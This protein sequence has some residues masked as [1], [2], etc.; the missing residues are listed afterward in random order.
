[1][2]K[3]L[4]AAGIVIGLLGL[5]TY[6]YIE[7]HPQEAFELA[8]RAERDRAMLSVKSVNVDGDN[9]PYLDGGEGDVVLLLHGFGGDKDNW[10][11]FGGHLTPDHRV[12][13][14]DLPGFGG[15]ARHEDQSYDIASQRDRLAAFVETLGLERF[16]LAGNSM[17]GN[18]AAAYAH[19]YPEKLLSLGLLDAAGVESPVPS[20]LAREVEA[21]G[22]VALIPRT[23]E[24]YDHM[25]DMV[26]ED[27][28]WVPP[29][30]VEAL[31]QRAIEN[32]D[33]RQKIF[34]EY[35]TNLFRLEPV[36]PEIQT[37]TLI[38]WGD[39]DRLI[40]VSAARVM[41]DLLPNSELAIMEG[42]GHC[43]MIE[44]PRAT[45][46]LYGPFIDRHT[47]AGM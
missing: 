27:K 21:T 23:R 43:P 33:F 16:H 12:I 40:H 24:D 3:F 46:E 5:G 20:E 31:A 22:R 25:V 29:F 9:W 36:L 38:I 1:M 35:R 30:V 6:A 41:D 19:S 45:V 14:P 8:L 47:P 18:L 17:G 32:A 4:I 34:V 15:N 11:R 10:T 42:M 39:S 28:P 37:P 13:A 44:D 2:S 26:F 7:T